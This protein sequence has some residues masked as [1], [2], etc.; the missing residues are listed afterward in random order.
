MLNK[1]DNNIWP[2]SCCVQKEDGVFTQFH[3]TITDV[4]ISRPWSV[5]KKM[6]LKILENSQENACASV[7]FLIKL[8]V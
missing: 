2:F 4:R 7:S 8:E 1:R 5:R 3:M 6:F